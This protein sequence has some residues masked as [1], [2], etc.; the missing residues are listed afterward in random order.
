MTARQI[1]VSGGIGSRFDG[2]A[3]GHDYEL[4]NERAYAETCAAIGNVMWNWRMLALEGDARYADTME[5]ALYNG[6]LVGLSLDGA[7]YFYQNPLAD[8]GTHRR[9][10][11]FD[12]ACC[13]PNISRLLASLP[14]HFFSSSDDGIWVHL[15][16]Q[17]RAKVAVPGAGPVHLIQETRYPW[18]GE[19]TIRVEGSGRFGLW[20]RI[21][22]WCETGASLEINGRAFRGAL[23]PGTY[24]SIRRA[25]QTGDRVRL[26]LPMPV[27]RVECHPNVAN[28]AG[29]VALVRGPLLYC[30]ERADNPGIDPRHLQLPED[31]TFST[32]CRGGQLGGV[33]VL[34]GPA[35]TVAP[36]SRWQQHLYR[37]SGSPGVVPEGQLTEV[38]AIPY[39]AWANR[40]PGPMQVW[41]RTRSGVT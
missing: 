16:A 13:P 21:P 12:C 14:G 33:V 7:S 24:A 15:Y 36:G 17:G 8:R 35:Y 23:V 31:A 37:T 39:Y 29:R 27:R 22:G 28:N 4:P 20:L 34:R 10:P 40:E 5:T 19:I 25:W 3:F 18:E 11:W 30:V 38:T 6:V 26:D 1:Y 2:E 9:R 41:L 32:E